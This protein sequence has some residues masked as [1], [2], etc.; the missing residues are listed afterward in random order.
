MYKVSVIIRT[1]PSYKEGI[2]KM[3]PF[4]KYKCF[5]FCVCLEWILEMSIVIKNFVF[6]ILTVNQFLYKPY[7]LQRRQY[8]NEWSWNVA[9][10]TSVYQS[11]SRE[12]W[13]DSCLFY[14]Y[15][16][17]VQYTYRNNFKAVFG[18]YPTLEWRRSS[19]GCKQFPRYVQKTT[20]EVT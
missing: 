11:I 19:R 16:C 13:S 1:L 18:Q 5:F 14:L 8:E 15:N 7:L 20:L 6:K 4:K 17:T 12:Q 3:S 9:W 10:R 2:I